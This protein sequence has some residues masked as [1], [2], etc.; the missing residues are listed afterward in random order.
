MTSDAYASDPA[1]A[2]RN[3]RPPAPTAALGA[4]LVVVDARGRVLLGLDRSGVWELPGGGV[5]P[6]ESIE[7]AAARE[8]AEETTLRADAADVEVLGLLLDTVTSPDLTRM[9]AATVV[10]SFTGTPSPAEP[11][12]IVRWEWTSP[13]GLPEALFLPSA[14][15]LSV[16]RP[17]LPLPEAPFHRYALG[18]AARHRAGRAGRD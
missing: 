18:R 9:T 13:D 7:E 14:Q 12:K 1:A 5:E 17:D 3:T 16:W 10:R 8:L 6:G 4:G 11:E 15:V 2:S